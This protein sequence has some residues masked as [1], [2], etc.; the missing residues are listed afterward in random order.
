MATF[1]IGG[2]DGVWFVY[3]AQQVAVAGPYV[4]SRDAANEAN[5]REAETG[6]VRSLVPPHQDKLRTEA[7]NLVRALSLHTYEDW[8]RT[9]RK[10][11]IG[12]RATNRFSR[13]LVGTRHNHEPSRA[14]LAR[15]EAMVEERRKARL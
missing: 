8:Q 6:G 13:R 7:F 5:R 1:T 2:R 14:I 3:D 12:Q 4:R 11:L 15:V 10:A 9:Y